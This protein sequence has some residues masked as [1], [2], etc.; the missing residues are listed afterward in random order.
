VNGR[1]V[2]ALVDGVQP[3]GRG[4]VNWNGLDNASR[5]VAS[6][7]YFVRLHTAEGVTQT[8]KLVFAR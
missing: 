8:R 7:I 5:P 3:A 6:G 1:V 4:T 2:R